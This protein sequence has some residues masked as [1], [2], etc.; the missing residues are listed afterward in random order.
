MVVLHP[1]SEIYYNRSMGK[2]N[3]ELYHNFCAAAEELGLELDDS[4]A[5]CFRVKV[6]KQVGD[7]FYVM[8]WTPLNKIGEAFN[9][10]L[11]GKYRIHKF[12]R[13]CDTDFHLEFAPRRSTVLGQAW[14]PWLDTHS[15]SKDNIVQ[16]LKI[17]LDVNNFDEHAEQAKLVDKL[18]F[19]D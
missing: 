15:A 18:M 17:M 1:L 10:H 11:P 4:D 5:R 19:E 9:E 16:A 8:L 3:F 7:R 2:Y 13:N 6:P 14:F 12:E